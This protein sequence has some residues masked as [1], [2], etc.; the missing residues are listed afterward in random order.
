MST[1]NARDMAN[2]ARE[3]V[4]GIW[5]SFQSLTGDEDGS[6]SKFKRAM[7]RPDNNVQMS[8]ENMVKTMFGSC[9]IGTP[10][11]MAP[12]ISLASRSARTRSTEVSEPLSPS[13]EKEEFFYSQFLSKDHSRAEQAVDCVREHLDARPVGPERVRS[14]EMKS[15]TKPFPVSSPVR[16]ATPV[17]LPPVTVHEVAP[18]SQNCDK[19]AVI[20]GAASFDDGISC[21]SAQTLEE[22]ARQDDLIR[23]R[24]LG[25]VPSDLTS[26]GFEA[27]ESKE[28]SLFKSF[29]TPRIMEEDEVLG[30]AVDL[31]HD[32]SRLTHTSKRSSGTK[33]TRSTQSSTFEHAWRQDEQKY[34]Q[35]VV[36][37]EDPGDNT[38]EKRREIMLERVKQLKERSRTP[39]NKCS[40]LRESVSLEI[41]KG[42]VS[43]YIN[44]V[45]TA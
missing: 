24:Q 19:Q 26:E 2:S 34:W 42:F 30:A 9:T 11:D 16:Q 39:T 43:H 6:L 22:M 13:R 41:G 5:A 12:P 35:E 27:M 18:L 21:L 37:L 14:A 38:P 3:K 45:L 10:E 7:G 1:P 31:S 33:S 25:T 4:Q 23:G 40:V 15:L 17:Y 20:P 29:S 32:H 28:S 8:W 36:E 44:P